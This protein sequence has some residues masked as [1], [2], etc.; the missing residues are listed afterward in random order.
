[1]EPLLCEIW[2][3]KLTYLSQLGVM[4]IGSKG[5]VVGVAPLALANAAKGNM[6]AGGTVGW[7]AGTTGGIGGIG[8]PVAWPELAFAQRSWVRSAKRDR[9]FCW[10]V[11]VE[12]R[13]GDVGAKIDPVDDETFNN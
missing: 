10:A 13:N 9:I 2:I 8:I 4:L 5:G 7:G 6:G 12:W 1:M 11:W 3:K